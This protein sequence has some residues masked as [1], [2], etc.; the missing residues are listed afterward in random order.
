MRDNNSN[1]MKQIS[2]LRNR[3]SLNNG[4]E[5]LQMEPDNDDTHLMRCLGEQ[6]FD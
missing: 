6:L 4:A 3:A 5:L 2:I 1:G